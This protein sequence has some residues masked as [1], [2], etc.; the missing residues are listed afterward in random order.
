MLDA[1]REDGRGW[2]QLKDV[3]ACPFTHGRN[4]AIRARDLHVV[5]T[6][7]FVCGASCPADVSITLQ[8]SRRRTSNRR[9]LSLLFS[10]STERSLTLA[11]V[12]PNLTVGNSLDYEGVRVFPLFSD[13]KSDLEYLLSEEALADQ[14]VL[15]REIDEGGSVPELIVE[16]PGD[17][18]VLFVEGEE[19]VGAKQNRI[20]NTSVLVSANSKCTIPV[21]CVEQNR[22]RYRSRHFKASGSHSPSSLRRTLKESV[23]RSLKSRRDYQSD[24][25]A[26]WKKVAALQAAHA[27]KS[28]TAAMSDAFDAYQDR[29]AEYRER[30]KYVDGAVGLV[31]AIGG[32]VVSLDVFDKPETCRRT[33]NKLLSGIVFDALEAG[34]VD[35]II[36]VD[37]VERLLANTEHLSWEQTE[38]VGDGEEYRAESQHGD[39]ASALSFE[40]VVV[41][42][43]VL[44][45]V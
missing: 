35:E 3:S 2:C 1:C 25:G 20:L 8:N 33:W 9:M 19:L 14:S 18:R 16:N 29:I 40:D 22:W 12:F 6:E 39:H 45:T 11:I 27:V 32:R 36:S 30:L 10:S 31:V 42:G 26:I 44:A 5:L 43:S 21:S 7:S 23:T 4:H 28:P 17:V 24:Q 37:N 41:H 13:R 38:A 34:P 15:I